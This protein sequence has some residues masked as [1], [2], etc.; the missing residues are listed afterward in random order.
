VVSSAS[1]AVSIGGYEGQLLDLRLAASWTRRCVAPEGPVVGV[2][3]LHQAGS[4]NGP[5]VGVG[6]NQPVRLILV[7]LTGGRTMAVVIFG[8]DPS[9]ASPFEAHVAEVMPIIESFEFHPPTP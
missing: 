6:P 5:G 2:P 8:I 7:D 4:G 3:I 1:T 9:Q